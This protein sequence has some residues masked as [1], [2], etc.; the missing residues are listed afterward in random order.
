MVSSFEYNTLEKFIC[1]KLKK[2]MMYSF[3]LCAPTSC[4]TD[5][6]H[7][8][9]ISVV[10]KTRIKFCFWAFIYMLVQYK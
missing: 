7:M 10:N 6:G 2:T 9:V 8:K 1:E 3:Q 5:I 4:Q